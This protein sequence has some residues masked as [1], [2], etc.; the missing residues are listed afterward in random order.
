MSESFAPTN[1]SDTLVSNQPFYHA[2]PNS[3]AYQFPTRFIQVGTL[4]MDTKE[5][6]TDHAESEGPSSSTESCKPILCAADCFLSTKGKPEDDRAKVVIS[7]AK[8][9]STVNRAFKKLLEGKEGKEKLQAELTESDR[10]MPYALAL[11]NPTINTCFEDKT[12]G[13]LEGTMYLTGCFGL[14]GQ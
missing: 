8:F 10:T 6:T 7:N 5:F 3:S 4:N 1:D 13:T 14:R 12:L 9:T 2:A 11:D